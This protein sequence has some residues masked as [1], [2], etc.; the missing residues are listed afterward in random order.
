LQTGNPARAFTLAESLWL[1][2]RSQPSACDPV[3]RAWRAAGRQS[4][5]LVWQRVA[6]A[7]DAGELRLAKYLERY[8][9]NPDKVWLNRWL[10]LH[11]DPQRVRRSQ[12]FQTAHP[13]RERMLAHAV[14]RL[15]RFDG[16]DALALWGE[17]QKRYPF[18]ADERY[19]VERRLAL[20]LASEENPQ[21]YRFLQRVTPRA[22][23]ERLHSALLRAA[24]Q[25]HDWPQLLDW[26]GRLPTELAE[27]ERW[28]YWRARAL[29]QTGGKA[30]AQSLYRVVARERS[31]YGF[32][33]ADRTNRPYALMHAATPVDP[34]LVERIGSRPAAL[35]ARELRALDRLTDARREWRAL[36]RSLDR[37]GLKAA[38]KLAEGWGWQDQAIFTLAKSGYWDD[39]ELRFPLQHGD[40]VFRHAEQNGLEPAWVYAVIRQESA[41]NRE[42]R[43]P[44][45]ARGLMQLMPATA[46]MVA[47]KLLERRA[48]SRASLYDPAV[49][50]DL[51]TTY[52][53]H[54]LDRLGDHPVLATAAYNAG[55]HRVK[56]WLPERRVDADVWVELVPFKE[57]RGYLR[58]VMYYTVIYESRL[59]REPGSLLARMQPIESATTYAARTTDGAPTG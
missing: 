53:R 24:L 19:D 7:M 40:E 34:E 1:H 5:E 23:D 2:G 16:F 58:R 50:I 18:S 59:G 29:E 30:E 21:A 51:G 56:G 37:A 12:D 38:A 45:G 39:L 49:N 10:R 20:T 11:R 15:S 6:L 54:V 33:A 22:E 41:F 14:R 25:R 52:L 26:L 27:N 13:Y 35:R 55:P 57:T 48:P 47:T 28:R 17:L 42:A 32:L 43:S 9:T 8:L 31:Y 44:A 36:Q 3:F 46:R 4:H